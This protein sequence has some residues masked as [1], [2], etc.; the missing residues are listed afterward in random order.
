MADQLRDLMTRLAEE[1]GPVPQDPTLWH[2]AR[3]SRRRD[4]W[5]AASAVAAVL[6]ALVAGTLVGIAAVRPV[7]AARGRTRQRGTRGRHPLV[8]P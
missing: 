2:R 1:A 7:C 5:L 3:R 6:L 4:Q 8:G